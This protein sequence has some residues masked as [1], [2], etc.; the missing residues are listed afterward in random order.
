MIQSVNNRSGI[1]LLLL[2]R[3]PQCG[4]ADGETAHP[5]LEAAEAALLQNDLS[6]TPKLM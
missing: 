2:F 4:A 3:L 6:F 5:V 1:T